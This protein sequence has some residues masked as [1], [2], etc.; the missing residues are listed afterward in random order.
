MVPPELIIVFVLKWT[1]LV[2]QCSYMA[3]NADG[4]AK[5]VDSDQTAPERAV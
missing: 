4:E 5:T 2:L 3:K 1:S